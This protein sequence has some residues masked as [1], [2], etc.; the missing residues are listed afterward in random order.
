MLGLDH[1]G[2]GSTNFSTFTWYRA[3]FPCRSLTNKT[4]WLSGVNKGETML[5]SEARCSQ[6]VSSRRV[7]LKRIKT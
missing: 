3:G 4:L 2:V 7:T 1:S 5:A 6:S